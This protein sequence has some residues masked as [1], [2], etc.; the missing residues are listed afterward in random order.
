[1]SPKLTRTFTL[2]EGEVRCDDPSCTIA[3]CGQCNI[4]QN[5]RKKVANAARR[6]A[7][8]A[9]AAVVEK[10][11]QVEEARRAEREGKIH[12]FT[13][14]REEEHGTEE[15]N[16]VMG[17]LIQMQVQAEVTAEESSKEV[18]DEFFEASTKK[19]ESKTKWNHTTRLLLYNCIAKYNPF[20]APVKKE[21]WSSISEEMGKA[22]IGMNDRQK[23]DFRVKTDGH[24][25]EVFYARQSELMHKKFS[26]EGSASGQAGAKITKE[27]HAE[28]A[29]LASCRAMEQE[30]IAMK[31]RKREAKQALEDLRNDKVTQAVRNACLD[32][33]PVRMKYF[34]VLQTRVRAAKLEASTWEKQNAGLGKYGYSEQQLQDIEQLQELTQEHKQEFD[35]HTVLE[36]D[37]DDVKVR[38]GA[39]AVAIAEIAKKLPDAKTFSAIDPATFAHTFFAAKRQHDVDTT[40][41]KRTLKD[42]L[43][44]VQEQL[45][46]GVIDADEAEEFKKKIKAAF[47]LNDFAK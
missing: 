14:D 30:V 47:F 23:G 4:E 17:N 5:R 40:P 15:H 9:A 20:A 46:E 41:K 6:Q 21:A 34:K 3:Q 43:D 31:D 25:L 1:M 36:S 7:A 27:E 8:A 38:G 22:T 26:T 19:K 24:G 10:E 28:Y 2:T 33:K 35:S 37:K 32:D 29:K 45:N 18:D 42:K 12:H 16:I 13:Y 44:E 11:R 39:V